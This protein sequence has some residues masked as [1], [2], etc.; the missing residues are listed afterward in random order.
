MWHTKILWRKIL[1]NQKKKTNVHSTNSDILTT[2]HVFL[3]FLFTR[4]KTVVLLKLY[5]TVK[6]RHT[7]K[8]NCDISGEGH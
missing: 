5:G 8:E 6:V 3:Y 7:R 2:F 1:T 4:I